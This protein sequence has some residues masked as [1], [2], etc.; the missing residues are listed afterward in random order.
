M[1]K[2]IK[3]VKLILTAL[4][5]VIALAALCLPI[6]AH[7][8]NEEPVPAA[9]APA[10]ATMPDFIVL[11]DAEHMRSE[12][13]GDTGK[14]PFDHDQ[15]VKKDSCVTCHH[16]NSKKL[17]A[18]MEEDVQKCATCH[19]ATAGPS[20]LEGTNEDKKF[21]GK[22]AMDSENAFHGK[23]SLV[24]CIGCHQ[25]RTIEPVA[26]K[27]CHTGEDTIEYKYKKKE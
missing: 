25:K 14:T 11:D 24:G 16:T 7:T 27:K 6:G 17:T 18:A 22:E 2:T 9:K 12:F 26:C 20:E 23:D 15:H 4:F 3:R 10:K 13:A 8:S 1:L 21:K 5:A 19:K